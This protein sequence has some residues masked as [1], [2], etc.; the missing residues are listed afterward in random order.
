[1]L[2][3]FPPLIYAIA[4]GA[5]I[6]L[7][8]LVPLWLLPPNPFFW[9]G[10]GLYAVAAVL[11]LWGFREFKRHGTA[12][13]PGPVNALVRKG[14]YRFS[15]NPLYVGLTVV[16]LGIG[17]S[18]NNVWI[19]A[20]APP[21]VAVVHRFIIKPEEEYLEERFGDEYRAYKASVRRWI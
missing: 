19:L 1:M 5:G 20:L 18:T 17:C 4:V 15:R 8:A 16:M 14:P 2:T 13:R 10:M 7:R 6:G 11:V 3:R 21:T 12:V 9:I